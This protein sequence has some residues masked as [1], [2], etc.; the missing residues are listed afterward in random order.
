M[1]LPLT[2]Q[3]RSHSEKLEREHL[4]GLETR[5]YPLDSGKR[6]R[7]EYGSRDEHE[8]EDHFADDERAASLMNVLPCAARTPRT[9][10][11]FG[12]TNAD[13]TC[14]GGSPGNVLG[15][16]TKMPP[17]AAIERWRRSTSPK[18]RPDRAYNTLKTAVL[19][20]IPSASVTMATMETM[21]ACGDRGWQSAS[22]IQT[23]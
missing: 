6:A 23:I 3:I 15:G 5:T 2:Q 14:S 4:P 16:V 13:L 22:E 19:T 8:S 20:P 21:D 18:I 11:K 17:S 1:P 7:C 9:S 10:K 12:V